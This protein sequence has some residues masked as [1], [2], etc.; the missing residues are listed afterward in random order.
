MEKLLFS[1][2]SNSIANDAA[3]K[4]STQTTTLY[5]ILQKNRTVKAP[6]LNLYN[7][8]SNETNTYDPEK[9]HKR[10]LADEDNNYS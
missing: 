3:E 2:T 4:P 7:L 8:Q 5:G 9:T 1:V 10:H 6:N